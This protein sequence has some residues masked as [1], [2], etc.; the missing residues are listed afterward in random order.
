LGP[1]GAGTGGRGDFEERFVGDTVGSAGY[2]NGVCSF[3]G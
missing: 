3:G 1:D 2:G